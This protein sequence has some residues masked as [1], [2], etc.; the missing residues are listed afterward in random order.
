MTDI[1]VTYAS[2][3]VT[4][5]PG[6]C[7]LMKIECYGAGGDGDN[8]YDGGAGGAGGCYARINTYSC[9]PGH[10]ITI[11]GY[12]ASV[13]IAYEGT[14]TICKASSGQNA[15]GNS[16]G[17]GSTLG[18]IGDV[19]YAGGNG[20]VEGGGGSSAT[21]T[22]AGTDANGT[23]GG[24]ASGDLNGLAGNGADVAG[25]GDGEDGFN[26]G[27]AGSGDNKIGGLVHIGDG[28]QG[29]VKITYYNVDQEMLLAFY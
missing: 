7:N 3:T 13:S 24:I 16:P 14:G 29:I 28:A 8:G 6:G 9:T 11:N 5:I 19:Y 23:L 17:L 22:G 15:S 26:Y 1:S 10:T 4:S 21:S 2:N 27:G 18:C 12:D 25:S 20:A